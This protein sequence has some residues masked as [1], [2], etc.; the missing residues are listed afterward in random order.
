MNTIVV[1]IGEIKVS[2]DVESV[3]KTYALGSCV[4]LIIYDQ[5][6]HIAGMIHIAL[7]ESKVDEAK[8][9]VSPG[10]FADT[11]V[12]LLIEEMKKLG[13]VRGS[14]WIKLAGG[15]K[16]MDPNSYFDIGKRNVLAI[17]KVLWQ[18]QMGPVAEDVGSDFSRTVT[19]SVKTGEVTINSGPKSW[20][21]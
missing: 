3:I 20:T 8:A 13:A 15:A 1:G 16:V 2:D 5:S 21:L 14:V 19:I 7:P 10:H 6:R 11:G 12:P 4:A 18:S 9:A 17:K